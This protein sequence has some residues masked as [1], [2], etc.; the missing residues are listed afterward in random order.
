MT[1]GQLKPT[2]ARGDDRQGLPG[3]PQHDD[4]GLT[5]DG[6]GS[7]YVNVGAPS[8]ACQQPGSSAGRERPGSV[9]D[10]RKAR[11]HLEVRREQAGTD[12]GARARGSRPACG[13][14]RPSRGTTARSTSSMNNRDQLD[15]FWPDE[16]TA[17]DNAERPAEPMYRAVQGS[18][19]GWP[20]CFFDYRQKKF[21][22][23]PEYG[24][25]GKD[26]AAAARSSRRRSRRSPRTGRR[27]TSCSTRARSSRRSITTAR[28]SRSTAR[29]TARRCRRP[30]TT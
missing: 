10:S 19:F 2:G 15:V 23:N 25:D 13:R 8:N 22:L 21:L 5:F 12:A 28:S 14:C 4:K 9:P 26:G 27:S 30:A 16:F 20:Y 11:R 3:E 17:K 6:N 1:A 18:N 29:G 24:G 7:L